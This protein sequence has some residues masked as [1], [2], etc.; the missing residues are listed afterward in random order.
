MNSNTQTNETV[1]LM[2]RGTLAIAAV[3]VFAMLP[4]EALATDMGKGT[5]LD[6]VLCNIVSFFTGAVGKGIAT[7]ALIIIGIGAL[8]GKISWGM[9]LIVALG[10]ALVFGA[11]TLVDALGAD[12][13]SIGS[14]GGC[15][16]GS[17]KITG[18]N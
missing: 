3:A 18:V 9:A 7:I 11:T 13:A 8:M 15:A 5:A 4:L 2:W 6:N 10:I 14:T 1:E 12:K 17:Y 16:T